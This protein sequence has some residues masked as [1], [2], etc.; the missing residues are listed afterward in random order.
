MKLFLQSCHWH[1]YP[2][3]SSNVSH[4]QTCRDGS[5]CRICYY[6]CLWVHIAL[7][8]LPSVAMYCDFAP[9]DIAQIS[10]V[11]LYW[12]PATMTVLEVTH[13]LHVS[14]YC[15]NF[16]RR[17]YRGLFWRCRA[18]LAYI[19]TYILKFSINKPIGKSFHTLYSSTFFSRWVLFKGN[20][21][22]QKL[23]TK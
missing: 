22:R 1:S 3:S 18:V 7:H 20:L 9:W 21:Y 5:V 16:T 15:R 19:R 11:G 23:T 10:L 13:R 8:P 17:W 4:E 2:R 12:D 14:V 6:L